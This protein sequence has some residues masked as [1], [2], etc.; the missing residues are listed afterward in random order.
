MTQKLRN[1]ELK[2]DQAIQKTNQQVKFQQPRR[3]PI[4]QVQ[5]QCTNSSTP[6]NDFNIQ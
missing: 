6:N 1:Q 3:T 2:T 5:F 4:F